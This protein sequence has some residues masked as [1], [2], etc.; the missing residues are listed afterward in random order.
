[1]AGAI[2]ATTA[3][4]TGL[5]LVGA[6]TASAST[7]SVDCSHYHQAMYETGFGKQY[8]FQYSGGTG[9]TVSVDGPAEVWATG[10][11]A[12]TVFYPGGYSV[13][14]LPGQHSDFAEIDSFQI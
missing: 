11:Y 9:N 4:L 8:C 1:M 10:S 13:R 3:A 7:P 12:V 6:T 5:G 2:A 14:L